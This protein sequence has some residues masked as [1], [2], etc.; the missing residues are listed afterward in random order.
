LELRQRFGRNFGAAFFVDGGHVS[1]VDNNSTL[2]APRTAAG[3]ASD[4]FQV[5]AGAGVRYYTPIGPIRFD[6][7]VP[8]NARP[9]D[10]RWVIY[11]G[12]GQAF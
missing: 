5:G 8:L 1:Y 10:D 11:I 7:A 4:G 6:V 12:L 2:L 9:S 3:V